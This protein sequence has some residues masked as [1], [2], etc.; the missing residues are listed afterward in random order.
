MT[1]LLKEEI[2]MKIIIDTDTMEIGQYPD[3]NDAHV[4]PD[5]LE[6]DLIE[7]FSLLLSVWS[8]K[9]YKTS[10]AR[11]MWIMYICKKATKKACGKWL[12]KR[13]K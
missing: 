2:F 12:I 5:E 1:A 4:A 6:S 7:L 8:L 11:I 10:K 9:L 13:F 3:Q